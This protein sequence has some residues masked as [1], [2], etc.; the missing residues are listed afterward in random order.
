VIPYCVRT[1]TRTTLAALERAGWRLL[2]SA[3]GVHR[4]EGFRYA[5]DNGAWSRRDGE[6]FTDPDFVFNFIKLIAFHGKHADFI[7]CPDKVGD[8]E[9]TRD[10]ID[11]W[12]GMDFLAPYL[13]H[14][15]VLLAVQDGMTATQIGH[16]LE[17]HSMLGIFVGGS[18]EWKEE[19]IPYWGAVASEVGCWV[20]VGRVNTARRIRMCKDA[21]ITSIDGSTV[22]MFPSSLEMVDRVVRE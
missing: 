16:Y 19:T 9:E 10:L 4:T 6:A 3:A 5:L 7:V 11:M 13:A 17:N 18:T 12:V 21:G 14:T 8:A 1:G 22:A 20:H 15:R 2:V